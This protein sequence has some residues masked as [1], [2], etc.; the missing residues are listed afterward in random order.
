MILWQ[1]KARLVYDGAQS[2]FVV[3]RIDLAYFLK[4]PAVRRW[5]NDIAATD[6]NVVP[7]VDPNNVFRGRIIWI[8]PP[9]CSPGDMKNNN[10]PIVMRMPEENQRTFVWTDATPDILR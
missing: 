8:F 1:I 5:Q 6:F 9:L 3:D 7:R 4:R 2:H 10:C